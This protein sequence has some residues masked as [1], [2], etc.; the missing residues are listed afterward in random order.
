MADGV[1]VKGDDLVSLSK[2]GVEFTTE[3]LEHFQGDRFR[4]GAP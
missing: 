4:Q 3:A 2:R 1:V